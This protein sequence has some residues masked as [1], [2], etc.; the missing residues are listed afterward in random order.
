MET[1]VNLRL[2]KL[3]RILYVDTQRTR[4]KL[5]LQLEEIFQ[6]SSNYARGRVE[7]V[8]GNDGKERPPTI[9]ERQYYARIAAYTASIINNLAKGIDERQIDKDLDL[10]EAMLNKA[11]TADK[12]KAD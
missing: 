4:R 9:A 6:I 1:R 10:L 2:N 7:R 12:A 3:K 5:I 8:V 11:K